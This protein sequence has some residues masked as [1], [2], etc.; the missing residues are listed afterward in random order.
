MTRASCPGRRVP[1]LLAAGAF[2]WAGCYVSAEPTGPL[3][4]EIIIFVDFSESIRGENQALIE[5]DFIDSIIPSLGAGDRI[6]VAAINEE[7]LTSFHPLIDASLPAMPV[8]NGWQDNTL[9]HK[10]RVE[11]VEAEVVQLRE[12]IESQ[13]GAMLANAGSSQKTDIFSSILMAAKLF[14]DQPSQ[15]VLIL[16]SDM[17]VDYPPY[18]FD[19]M[20]WSREKNQELIRELHGKGLIPDLSGV[21]VYV[22]GASARSAE[23][24]G[25]IGG[26]WQSYFRQTNADLDPSRYA[27]VLLHWPPSDACSRAGDDEDT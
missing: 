27:H 4:K 8:F 22:S 24:V 1:L 5:L 16:M 3:P 10:E 15:K 20:S 14:H 18:R 6:L 13:V 23:L 9:R 7:T 17:I 25:Q 12:E 11:L 26:F 2:L 19:R 21:C